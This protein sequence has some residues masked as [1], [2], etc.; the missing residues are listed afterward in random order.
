[1]RGAHD[2]G[3]DLTAIDARGAARGLL[4]FSLRRKRSDGRRDARVDACDDRVSSRDGQALY[5][6]ILGVDA[7]RRRGYQV[8]LPQAGDA[9]PSRT[10][11]RATR[12]PSTASRKSTRPTRS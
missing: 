12:T 5:Y 1:M 6:E 8:R 3:T 10:A 4:V 11:I 9:M 2:A 7:P